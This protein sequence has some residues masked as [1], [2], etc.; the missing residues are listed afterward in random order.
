MEWLTG[1]TTWLLQLIQSLWDS[2]VAFLNDIWISIAD[3]VLSA[4][5]S[6]IVSIPVPGFMQTFSLS[7]LFSSMP[8]DL[9]YF[10]SFLQLG[11][12]FLIISAGLAFR[13]T[14]KLLTLFQW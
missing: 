5:A 9:L 14:R 7:S 11:Q 1:L 6:V 3:T 12:A 2:G 4:I 8:S 13:L 10:L